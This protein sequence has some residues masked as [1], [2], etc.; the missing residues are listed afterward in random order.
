M[1][2]DA[3]EDTAEVFG[4]R[5]SARL[6]DLDGARPVPQPPDGAALLE[7]GEDAEH[8]RLAGSHPGADLHNGRRHALMLGGILADEFERLLLAAREPEGHR[9]FPHLDFFFGGFGGFFAGIAATAAAS[10]AAMAAGAYVPRSA[11]LER[12][13]RRA[14]SRGPIFALIA[15][16]P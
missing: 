6:D 13:S 10:F 3:D 5:Q 4:C 15:R 7:P 9:F 2:V 1:V 16:R 8:I 12:C 11:G 14:S